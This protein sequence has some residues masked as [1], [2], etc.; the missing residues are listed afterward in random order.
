MNREANAPLR[1][2]RLDVPRTATIANNRLT[3]ELD[4]GIWRLQAYFAA[5]MMAPA[6][7]A[8]AF[9]VG[10]KD[11]IAVYPL[12]TTLAGA[13]GELLPISATWDGSG[14]GNYVAQVGYA[15]EIEIISGRKLVAFYGPNSGEV[16]KFVKVGESPSRDAELGSR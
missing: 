2:A 15:V 8:V 12:G 9:S 16:I 5:S 4:V 3:L 1:A 10:N 14:M 7:P 11:A 13:A 6:A